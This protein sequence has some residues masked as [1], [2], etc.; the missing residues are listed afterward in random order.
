MK[1]LSKEEIDRLIAEAEFAEIQ[2]KKERKEFLKYLK[3][4]K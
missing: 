4:K 1:N 3:T 2:R